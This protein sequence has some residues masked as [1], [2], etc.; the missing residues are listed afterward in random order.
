VLGVCGAQIYLP[1]KSKNVK[2]HVGGVPGRN[3][4]VGLSH[5]SDM[6]RSTFRVQ[7]GIRTR[8][9]RSTPHSEAFIDRSRGL[10]L[11]SY[12]DSTSTIFVL[13]INL[14]SCTK[15]SCRQRPLNSAGLG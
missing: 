10:G 12:R 4:A 13:H 7:S 2:C 8:G 1:R 11:L 5:N 3:F 6:Q 9:D 15:Y 14:D